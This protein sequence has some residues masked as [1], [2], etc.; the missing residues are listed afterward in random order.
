MKRVKRTIDRWPVTHPVI[1]AA[2]L[3]ERVCPECGHDIVAQH[4]AECCP[5]CGYVAPAA[6][7]V[8]IERGTDARL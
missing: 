8:F 4:N 5:H 7:V 6:R 2:L 3:E 1:R